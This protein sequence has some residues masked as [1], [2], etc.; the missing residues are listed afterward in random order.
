MFFA[1]FVEPTSRQS[2][3][4]PIDWKPYE[5]PLG[6]KQIYSRQSLV[7][8]IDWKLFPFSRKRLKAPSRQSLVTPIDWKPLNLGLCF[9]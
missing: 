9:T 6:G 1:T 3:V 5:A 2:L 8:P 4:T 7:T